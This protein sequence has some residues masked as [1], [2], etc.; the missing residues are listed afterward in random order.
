MAILAYFGLGGPGQGRYRI[1]NDRTFLVWF[2]NKGTNEKVPY[3]ALKREPGSNINI[4]FR[5]VF[6]LCFKWLLKG[7]PTGIS[8]ISLRLCGFLAADLR[9]F[10]EALKG[11]IRPLRAL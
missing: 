6:W 5:S 7:L 10:Q 2:F 4:R 1:H 3:D 8:W 9:A 11:L